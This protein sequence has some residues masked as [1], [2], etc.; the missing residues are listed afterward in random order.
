[1][2]TG[3]SLMCGDGKQ[4]HGEPC[5]DQHSVSLGLL[6]GIG[7]ARWAHRLNVCIAGSP[8]PTGL[9]GACD[10]VL[11]PYR[12]GRIG[13]RWVG[14]RAAFAGRGLAGPRAEVAG[15]AS[16]IDRCGWVCTRVA[17]SKPSF[18]HRPPPNNF[19]GHLDTRKKF[20]AAFL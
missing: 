19:Y 20:T 18:D 5:P 4:T 16:S 15:V 10:A 1:M 2:V 11:A 6:R 3:L 14:R 12:A 13:G 9:D 7:R 8:R 17:L